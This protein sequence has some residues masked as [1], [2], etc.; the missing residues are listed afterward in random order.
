MTNHSVAAAF[1][2]L[3]DP[4]R[5][6]I[7]ERLG[8]RTRSVGEV[9]AGLPVTRPAVSQHLKVLKAARLVSDHAD[10]TRRIY[11]LDPEG[12]A[13]VRA[14]FEQFWNRSLA[15]FKQAAEQTSPTKEP[16]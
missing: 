4:T 2:A 7:F 10:G 12:L 3:A 13:A 15:A 11:A 6:Q 14:Y 8:Q 9:A 16:R 5:R 1:V